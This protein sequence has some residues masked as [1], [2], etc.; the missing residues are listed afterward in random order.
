MKKLLILLSLTLLIIGCNA[1][2][3]LELEV[4]SK[5]ITSIKANNDGV[6][7]NML[8]KV[9]LKKSKTIIVYKLTNNSK[10]TYY[11]NNDYFDSKL[12]NSISGLGINKAFISF[13][14]DKGK[15]V[16]LKYGHINLDYES[17][18]LSEEKNDKIAE[19]LNYKIDGQQK[20]ILDNYNFVIHPDETLYF[21]WFLNLP[22]G[23]I[24]QNAGIN[25]DD[26]KDYNAEITMFSDSTNY[27]KKLSRTVLQ[28]IKENGY[29]VYH[30]IIKSK[31]KVPIKFVD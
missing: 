24:I 4:V 6:Y 16:I 21:E 26:K 5:S 20:F 22:Y 28:T 13:F 29:E 11:F 27:K 9:V 12:C 3:D 1:Q 14:D 25:F 8:N 30:G 19:F 2:S 17:K 7:N 18:D 31:N 10:K 15:E 23:N